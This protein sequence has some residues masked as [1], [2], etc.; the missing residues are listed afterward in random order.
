MPIV[1]AVLGGIDFALIDD[2]PC[3]AIELAKKA[4]LV[5]LVACGPVAA[6]LDRN[7]D[8]VGVAVDANLVHDLKISRLLALAPQLVAR[9]R[10]IA[11]ASGG[12][13]LLEGLAI[14]IG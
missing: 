11:R 3:A 7:H 8:R 2:F 5:A 13:R 9:P 1:G 10:E 6:L 14:H 4:R 12:D